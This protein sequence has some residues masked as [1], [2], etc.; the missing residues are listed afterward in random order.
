MYVYMYIY[1]FSKIVPY[2]LYSLILRTTY[3]SSYVYTVTPFCKFHKIRIKNATRNDTHSMSSIIKF[4]DNQRIKF[5]VFFLFVHRSS[6]TLYVTSCSLYA[7]CP[8]LFCKVIVRPRT[9]IALSVLSFF[10]CV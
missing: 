1:S 3:I 7:F 6:N 4:I 5:N 10:L 2:R 9:H 8:F